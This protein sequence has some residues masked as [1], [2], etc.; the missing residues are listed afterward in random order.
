MR[1]EMKTKRFVASRFYLSILI[2]VAH[3]PASAWSWDWVN[4]GELSGAQVFGAMLEGSDGHIYASTFPNGDLFRT[5]DPI[6]IDEDGDGYFVHGGGC[7]DIDC[8]D[9]D[10]S[11]HPGAV[12]TECNEIDEDCNRSDYC[13]PG[14]AG[15][16]AEASTS[17]RNPLYGSSGLLKHLACFLLPVWVSRF[18]SRPDAERN[19]RLFQSQHQE[20]RHPYWASPFFLG[21]RCSVFMSECC[22][23]RSC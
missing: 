18:F 7:G 4:T 15:A 11:I 9:S 16:T 13:P 14:C 17:V 23:A 22:N 20:G 6:C 19:R 5:S 2:Y 3:C 12:E 1:G 21:I 10:P 8:E